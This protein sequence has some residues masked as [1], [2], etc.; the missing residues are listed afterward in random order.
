[1]RTPGVLLRSGIM[2]RFPA[3]PVLTEV[4]VL[5]G[6]GCR[7]PLL[8]VVA[9]QFIQQVQGLRTHQV[10]VFRLDELLPAFPRLPEQH[11]IGEMESHQFSGE[12]LLV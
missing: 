2:N 10:L 4:W 3:S 8:V 12:G 1:M 9:Q 5:H 7:Q 11:A 6:L